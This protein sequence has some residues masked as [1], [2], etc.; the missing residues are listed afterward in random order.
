M[1]QA[2]CARLL[3][4]TFGSIQT[5][6]KEVREYSEAGVVCML[7]GTKSDLSN[8][9]QVQQGDAKVGIGFPP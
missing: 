9:R 3:A 4:G 8:I 7:V 6:L 1:Q 5:W 2:V